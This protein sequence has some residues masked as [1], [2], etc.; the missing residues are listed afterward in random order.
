[1][2]T[3]ILFILS[4][5]VVVACSNKDDE[6]FYQSKSLNNY[7]IL[8]MDS[9][10]YFNTDTLF[11][12]QTSDISFWKNY[13]LITDFNLMKLWVFNDRLKL[14]KVVGRKGNGPGEYREPPSILAADDSIFLVNT[15]SNN[16]DLYDRNFNFIKNIKLPSNITFL[17]LKPIN[18]PN[19]YIFFGFNPKKFSEELKEQPT[20]FLLNKNFAL[21][22]D[23]FNWDEKYSNKDA[24]F[25]SN[26]IVLLTEGDSSTFFVK[27]AA[28]NKIYHFN[29]DLENIKS[30]GLKPKFFREPPSLRFEDTQKSVEAAV[31]FTTKITLMLKMDFDLE[32]R[33]LLINYVNLNE[34][35]FYNRSLL[36]GKHYLQI[37]NENYDCIFDGE[38]PGKL[39][40]ITDGKIYILTEEKP[41]YI[42]FKVFKLVH[43]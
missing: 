28:I 5:Y 36:F 39:A 25:L 33:F 16:V 18:L 13:I 4:I 15:L 2:K 34:K 29:E 31:D 8:E 22:K 43:I 30:F 40:F 19:Y 27:Q 3:V 21:I 14:I 23:F 41:E 38:I 10:T 1:M 7:K 17:P 32:N 11:I 42:K 35:F 20:L 37:Y 6:N 12:S 26:L 24:F 9:L